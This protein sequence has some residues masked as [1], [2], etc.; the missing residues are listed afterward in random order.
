M[1]ALVNATGET[2]H[3][4]IDYLIPADCNGCP[5]EQTRGSNLGEEH[6]ACTADQLLEDPVLPSLKPHR[7]R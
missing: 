3:N 7:S 2:V 4:A 5:M 6:M 1:G